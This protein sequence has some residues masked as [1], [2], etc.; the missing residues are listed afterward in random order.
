MATR[1]DEIADGIFR[2]STLIPDIAPPAGF[3]FNQFLV[4][5]DE[6]LIFHCGMRG[7]FA[8]VSTAVAT[9]MPIES[10]SW[11]SFGHVEA[12]ECGS[13]NN[14]LATA[15]QAQVV[16]GMTE[17]ELTPIWTQMLGQLRRL[18]AGDDSNSAT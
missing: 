16:H 18:R 7:L 2:I 1:I 4:V 3:S 15:P 14:W 11:I 10:I 8:A 6:P 17:A 12:D 13:M 5:A 9:V